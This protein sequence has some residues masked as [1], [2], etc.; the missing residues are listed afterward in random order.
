MST[1]LRLGSQSYADVAAVNSLPRV[2]LVN[3]KTGQSLPDTFVVLGDNILTTS[4]KIMFDPRRNSVGATIRHFK[5][6]YAPIVSQLKELKVLKNRYRL[7]SEQFLLDLQ[8]AGVLPADASIERLTWRV[9]MVKSI[10]ERYYLVPLFFLK[11][12]S[13]KSVTLAQGSL[14]TTLNVFL[15]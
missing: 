3:T 11:E 12:E 4:K 7:A 15:G 9:G 6:T 10:K 8:A 1:V 13:V 2:N 14:E 5:K